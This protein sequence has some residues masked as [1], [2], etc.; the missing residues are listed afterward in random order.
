MGLQPK[1]RTKVIRVLSHACRKVLLLAEKQAPGYLDNVHIGRHTYGCSDKTFFL[2]TGRELV[3]IGNFCSV[4]AGVEF[5]FGD[6]SLEKVS[7][8]PLRFLLR[9]EST[10]NDAICRGP[11]SV[12]NDVWL[13][14]N[15][16][17]MANVRIGN[18]A[19]VAAGS[20]VT[21]DVPAYTIVGGVPARAIRTRF[22]L[23]QIENLE[24]IAWWNWSDAEILERMDLF[25]SD[26]DT[27]IA[28]FARRP[29]H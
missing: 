26:V 16:V 15:A 19:V 17:I 29:E 11:I 3:T 9:K 7:T 10:N 4:A 12:G 18:G 21:R 27:F 14:R 2:P 25:Y 5:I 24:S 23:N 20:V 13:G 22:S 8:Y 28:A 1:L 6:H